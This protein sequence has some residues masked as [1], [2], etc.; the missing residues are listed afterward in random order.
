M[1]QPRRSA[2]SPSRHSV[3]SLKSMASTCCCLPLQADKTAHISTIRA[4]LK[5]LLLLLL[6]VRALCRSIT[7]LKRVGFS[8]LLLDVGNDTHS[9]LFVRLDA[10]GH[11]ALL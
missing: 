1:P 5:R 4:A 10:D 3:L 2:I 9:G 8:E 6:V 11:Q 7:D